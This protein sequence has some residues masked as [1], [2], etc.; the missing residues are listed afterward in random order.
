MKPFITHTISLGG[1]CDVAQNAVRFGLRDRS[2]VFDWLWNLD[3]GLG[4]VQKI[5]ERDFVGFCNA[6]NMIL[7]PHPRWNFEQKT[8]H[9]DYPEI[10]F[11][12][13]DAIKDAQALNK[14]KRRTERFQQ[15]LRG[16]R[17]RRILF[18]YYRMW[19][20]PIR[21]I[22]PVEASSIEEKIHVFREEVNS[23]VPFL[24]RQ[25]PNLKWE[26]LAL[27]MTPNGEKLDVTDEIAKNIQI[28]QAANPHRGILKFDTVL[29]RDDYDK[30][31]NKAS[32]M[33]WRRVYGSYNLVINKL[34]VMATKL[35]FGT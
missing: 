30:R 16:E 21:G 20:E 23:F 7:A 26:L 5:I 34:H 27:F 18:V 8:V 28:L 15:I 19:N 3:G 31:K 13:N 17:G 25:Y 9:R 6:D 11:I 35:G 4:T 1:G 24:Q 10:A 32:I 12:H 2:Y 29:S 33:D 22:Y 14:L